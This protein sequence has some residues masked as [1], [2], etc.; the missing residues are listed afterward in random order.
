MIH[1]VDE[2]ARV[3]RVNLMQYDVQLISRVDNFQTCYKDCGK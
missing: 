3:R 2:V 1:G